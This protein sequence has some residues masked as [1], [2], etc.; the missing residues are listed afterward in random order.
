MLSQELDLVKG[1][2]SKIQ[3]LEAEVL[4]VP[5]FSN[6]CGNGYM[7]R[8]AL[9]DASSGCDGKRLDDCSK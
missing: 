8:L 4:R 5:N 6:P 7:D 9:D 2:V 3:E 1:Y